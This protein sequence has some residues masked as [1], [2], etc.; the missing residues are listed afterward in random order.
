MSASE[1]KRFATR[2][3]HAGLEPDPHYRSIIPAIH[4]TS[5]FVQSAVGEVVEGYD[6]ARAANPTRTALERALGELE[7]GE[8]LVFSSGMAAVTA[9]LMTLIRTSCS[10]RSAPATRR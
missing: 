5:T 2:A 6:Y 8:S 4:Q 10:A 9:T 1:G 3:V 7:R